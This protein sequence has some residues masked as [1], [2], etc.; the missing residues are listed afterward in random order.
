MAAIVEIN[1][2]FSKGIPTRK[3]E[4]YRYEI[5]EYASAQHS[6][7][8]PNEEVGHKAEIIDEAEVVDVGKK[9]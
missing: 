9:V 7:H 4:E 5:A 3:W 8:L 6:Q 2:M 1:E